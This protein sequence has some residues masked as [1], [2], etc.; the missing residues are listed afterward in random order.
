M[1]I[2]LQTSY[3][4]P[5][6]LSIGFST[7]SA[8]D[9]DV[10]AGKELVQENCINCHGSELYTRKIRLV[11]SRSNLT[12][13]VQRCELALDLNWFDKDVENTAEFLNQEFYHFKQ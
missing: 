12:T 10:D 8:A 1:K 9:F 3:L 13:Q 11:K 7:V 6:M 2:K 5:L 4:L